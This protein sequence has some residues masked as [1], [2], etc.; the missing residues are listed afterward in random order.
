M[1]QMMIN[2]HETT[3][4]GGSRRKSQLFWS[5]K[6]TRARKHTTL[7]PSSICSN[8]HP[9]SHF[10]HGLQCEA[11]PCIDTFVILAIEEQD[12]DI[13][14]GRID[15]WVDEGITPGDQKLAKHQVGGVIDESLLISP[16][17]RLENFQTLFLGNSWNE[18]VYRYTIHVLT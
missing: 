2:P 4:C 12:R 14:P 7:V 11:A 15:H 18:S 5:Q 8:F 3:F 6:G 1:E 9:W 13:L 16:I 10:H 17:P